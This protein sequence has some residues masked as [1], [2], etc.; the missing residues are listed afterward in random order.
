[1]GTLAVL[2]GSNS[3]PE[4]E[5]IRKTYGQMDAEAIKVCPGHNTEWNIVNFI[6]YILNRIM[7]NIQHATWSNYDNASI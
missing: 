2:E 6:S 4:F 7:I 5:E 1:M 3:R